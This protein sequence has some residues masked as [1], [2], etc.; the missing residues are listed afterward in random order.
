MENVRGSARQETM[1]LVT[2]VTDMK[3][4]N[5]NSMTG[6]VCEGT[7]ECRMCKDP[8]IPGNYEHGDGSDGHEILEL[9]L[10]RYDTVCE[11]TDESKMCEDPHVRKLWN[12]RR[13]WQIWNTWT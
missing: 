9:E 13:Q 7:D 12:L 3:Y 2:T 1:N 8:H 10:E 11:G 4:L 5:L 6:T